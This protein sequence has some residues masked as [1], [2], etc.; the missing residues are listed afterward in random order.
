M[1]IAQ[2]ISWVPPRSLA[3]E[4]QSIEKM[5]DVWSRAKSAG[6]AAALAAFYA[7]DFSADGRDLAAHQA[8]LRADAARLRSRALALKDVSILG[9]SEGTDVRVVTFAEVAAGARTGKQTRQYW[10]RRGAAWKIVYETELR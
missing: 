9:W 10:E 2:Q 1:L 7:P 5:L 6:D 8:L 4:K 3:N